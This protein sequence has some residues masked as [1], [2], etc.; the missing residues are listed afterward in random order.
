M[1]YSPMRSTRKMHVCQNQLHV[2]RSFRA[3]DSYL[4]YKFAD[5]NASSSSAASYIQYRRSLMVRLVL[6][7]GA[8]GMP[9]AQLHHLLE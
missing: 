2:L 8:V 7:L 9:I 3:S 6:V 1:L 5:S 4:L